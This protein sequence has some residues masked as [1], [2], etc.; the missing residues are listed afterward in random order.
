MSSVAAKPNR[1]IANRQSDQT[2]IRAGNGL[3]F[4]GMSSPK[5]LLTLRSARNGKRCHE[6]AFCVPVGQPASTDSPPTDVVRPHPFASQQRE[7]NRRVE[8]LS[9]RGVICK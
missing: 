2:T 7:K 1:D 3:V 5:R 8:T 4:S 9:Y 6:T